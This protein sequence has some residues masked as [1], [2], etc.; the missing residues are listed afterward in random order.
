MNILVIGGR[1]SIGG[2][3]AK[4]YTDLGHT[5]KAT[6]KHDDVPDMHGMDIVIH[7]AGLKFVDECEKDP[8]SCVRDNVLLTYQMVEIAKKSG[9]KRFVFLSTDKACLPTNLMGMAKRLSEAM[10]LQFGYV[11][12]RLVNVIETRGNVFELWAKQK[13]AGKPLTVTDKRMYRYFMTLA[14]AVKAIRYVAEDAPGL[15]AWHPRESKNLWH[16]AEIQ[17]NPAGVVETGARP[18]EKFEENLHDG[19]NWE[20]VQ[21]DLWKK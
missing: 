4:A 1:G 18:G 8:R 15:Y 6:D 7:C 10:V 19:G 13:K 16:L 21:G 9:V 2:A 11:V 14:E 17:G 3:V 5:V 20:R 12:I